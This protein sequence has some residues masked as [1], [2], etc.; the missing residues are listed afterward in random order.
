MYTLIL[1][2]GGSGSRMK[3]NMPKQ[4]LLLA[5][6]PVI[7]HILER[8]DRIKEI[9]E[10][11]IVCTDEYIPLIRGM[12]V[13]YNVMVPVTFAR[14][15]DTRQASVKSGLKSVKT[16]NV[17][18]H[19]AARPFVSANDFIRLMREPCENVMYGTSIPFTVIRGH[20]TVE[21]VLDRS[22]LVNVQ[23]PQKFNTKIL[24][25]AHEKAEQEGRLFTEDAGLV[26]HYYPDINIKI[27]EGMV[28]NIKLTTSMD[29]VV[30]EM[31]Y[32]E[33]FVRR[34]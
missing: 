2:A 32:K 9:A 31:I 20:D 7:M 3:K 34:K 28:Y 19:E 27:C 8:I 15:G 21:G 33:Y 1:L 23:L 22:E 5:G 13:Q 30:G 18:L 16:K 4:Y 11:V 14:A 6:K 17:I 12:L 26:F 10:I 24:L 25:E 29:F